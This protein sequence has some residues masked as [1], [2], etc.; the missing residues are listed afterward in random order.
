MY[1]YDIHM[2][3][4]VYA[5][6]YTYKYVCM[7]MYMHIHLYSFLDIC[8]YIATWCCADSY[9]SC[10]CACSRCKA[11]SSFSEV[12]KSAADSSSAVCIVSHSMHAQSMCSATALLS[13]RGRRRTNDSTRCV[14]VS[15]SRRGTRATGGGTCPPRHR[16]REYT[17]PIYLKPRLPPL[18]LA[19]RRF[20]FKSARQTISSLCSQRQLLR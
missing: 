1:I 18:L 13:G 8:I 6:V 19:I 9:C 15:F 4:Y 17:L 5:Y 11:A 12:R 10:R 3:T 20:E 14:A 16:S 7:F 2:H